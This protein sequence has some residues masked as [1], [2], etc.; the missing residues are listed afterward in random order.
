M[1]N[2]RDILKRERKDHWGFE[3]QAS[4]VGTQ[5]RPQIVKRSVI[6]E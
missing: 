3:P 4:V 6:R 5:N 2:S 1:L